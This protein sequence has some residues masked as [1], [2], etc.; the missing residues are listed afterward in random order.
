[1]DQA[2]IRRRR[3]NLSVD[4]YRG[5]SV[6][7]EVADV[8]GPLAAQVTAQPCPLE[9][10]RQ[11]LAYAD[12]AHE[13]AGS[14]TRWHAER[15]ARRR[16]EH[17]ADDPGKRKYAMTTICDLAPRP[18]LPKITD[19]MIADGSWA[20]ALVEMVTPVDDALRDLLATAFPPGAPALR[21]RPSRSHVLAALLRETVD[22]A[23]MSLQRAL[24]RAD[25]EPSA[26]PAKPDPRAELAAL[27][28]DV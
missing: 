19:E 6:C 23:A 11:V 14:M 18:A 22:R 4:D 26:L 1:M 28:I 7:R 10:R 13:A 16:T 8:A 17:L 21:G 20:V 2:E 25:T 24:D 9:L 3:G 27:G 12:A 5:F 15:D